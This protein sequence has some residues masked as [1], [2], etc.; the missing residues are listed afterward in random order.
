MAM[1]DHDFDAFLNT[2]IFGAKMGVVATRHAGV[3]GSG[4][5]KPTKKLAHWVDLFDQPLSQNR[6]LV[7]NHNPL[8]LN[9]AYKT[10]LLKKRFQQ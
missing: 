7:L 1:R 4:A 9:K 8:P 10:S 6:V 5:T 3:K 2:C